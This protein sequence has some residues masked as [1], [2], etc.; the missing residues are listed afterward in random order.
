M[1]Q[2]A[3]K[4]EVSKFAARIF[5]FFFFILIFFFF[6]L[7]F[8]VAKLRSR[9]P[10]DVSSFTPEERSRIDGGKVSCENCSEKLDVYRGPQRCSN[11]GDLVCFKCCFDFGDVPHLLVLENARS[12]TASVCRSCWAGVKRRLLVEARSAGTSPEIKSRIEQ[13]ISIGDKFLVELSSNDIH[14]PLEGKFSISEVCS[15]SCP[16]CKSSFGVWVPP[17]QCNRCSKLVC[18]QKCCS[19]FIATLSGSQCR[20]CWGMAKADLQTGLQAASSESIALQ[21]RKQLDI[22]TYWLETITPSQLSDSVRSGRPIE[23]MS[24]TTLRAVKRPVNDA[25]CSLCHQDFDTEAHHFSVCSECK[26]DVCSSCGMDY[27]LK[28]AGESDARFICNV[29]EHAVRAKLG[30]LAPP[31]LPKQ[32][33]PAVKV[34]AAVEPAQPEKIVAL[35]GAQN[36]R[37]ALLKQQSKAIANRQTS[38]FRVTMRPMADVTKQ[39]LQELKDAHYFDSLNSQTWSKIVSMVPAQMFRPLASVNTAMRDLLKN[40]ASLLHFEQKTVL[41]AKREVAPGVSPA[42]SHVGI[43]EII[44]LKF[45][46]TGTSMLVYRFR[47]SVTPRFE[48]ALLETQAPKFEL[49]SV[50]SSDGEFVA[51]YGKS[52]ADVGKAVSYHV[53][54]ICR[55]PGK[56]ISDIVYSSQI[57]S[58]ALRAV[59]EVMHRGVLF[60][61]HHDKNTSAYVLESFDCKTG[62]LIRRVT[63][64][65]MSTGSKVV[66]IVV[67]A[68]HIYMLCVDD[69]SET[70]FLVISHSLDLTFESSFPLDASWDS[71]VNCLVVCVCLFVFFFFLT[72]NKVFF[73]KHHAVYF[74]AKSKSIQEIA[75]DIQ[76]GGTRVHANYPYKLKRKEEIRSILIDST[77]GFFFFFF[78]FFLC[79]LNNFFLFYS[80]KWL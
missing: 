22:G 50:L 34:A 58:Q 44:S 23:R 6:Q 32:A 61:A 76:R 59:V 51:V 7:I 54:R 26:A 15:Q 3:L 13:E 68:R 14:N 30:K 33:P 18:A 38:N 8:K 36:Q 12:M 1:C 69:N 35:P 5:F 64:P 10:I 42:T 21:L 47:P 43:D 67:E 2:P 31:E 80:F 19:Q 49:G 28:S 37:M 39:A 79:F 45:G 56:N 62:K 20:G 75:M 25:L 27:V 52:S 65:G 72:N 55:E 57:T 9:T 4:K 66:T 29:C 17:V 63:Q 70:P 73:V 40:W 78:F 74:D 41:E 71:K 11:C 53:Y 46:P 77:K 48:K 60:V 16:Y 24:L